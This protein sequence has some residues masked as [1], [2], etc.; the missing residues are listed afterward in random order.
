MWGLPL[1]FAD[2]RSGLDL[3]NIHIHEEMLD[4]NKRPR[5]NDI[6]LPHCEG[7]RRKFLSKFISQERGTR[8]INYSFPFI[9]FF[10]SCVPQRERERERN[11]SGK[12][13]GKQNLSHKFQPRKSQGEDRVC[14][15]SSEKL[16][17][18]PRENILIVRDFLREKCINPTSDADDAD[19]ECRA[20]NRIS[21]SS[22]SAL[23]DTFI[24]RDIEREKGRFWGRGGFVAARMRM[25]H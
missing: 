12:K 15:F 24:S 2:K 13:K 9:P 22:I 5:R 8:D 25:R 6:N 14:T 7:E 19:M 20:S 23:K 4:Q 11:G 18:F 10:S 1:S 17:S 16:F 3:S 21:I